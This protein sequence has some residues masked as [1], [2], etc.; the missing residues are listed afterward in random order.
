MQTGATL[1]VRHDRIP[2]ASGKFCSG[3]S[4]HSHTMHS[5]EYLGRLPHYIA[6]IPVASYVIEREVGWMHLY[7]GRTIDFSKMY[8]T[9]P[10]SP[11]EA[12][13]LERKQVEEKL[14][15]QA[16]VSLSDHDNIEA[17]LHLQMLE[18][19][20][21]APVS[22]EWSVPYDQT[23]FHLGVHNLPLSRATAWMEELARFTAN[24]RT[25][26]LRQLL[27]ELN[28]EPSVLLI[29]NH[30]YW[31]AESVGP[32]QHRDSLAIF[33][34]KYGHLL[35]SLEFNGMRSRSEN[36]QVLKLSKTTDLPVVS[37]GDRHGCEPNA[38][39]NLSAAAT[40]A[41]FVDEIRLERRSQVVLMPQYFEPLRLRLLEG[42]WH[43][44]SDAPGEFGRAHWM[45]RVF[46]PGADDSHRPLSDFTG[47][48]FQRVVD[49]FRRIMAFLV[50]PKM[51]PA[52]RLTFLGNEEGGL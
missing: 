9:P 37:G 22:V 11:R 25:D 46:I 43:A 29:L 20:K 21:R 23:V 8:W 32:D 1:V 31:D 5:R 39:L 2:Q 35:H 18:R 14:G 19:T 50:S 4:L 28:A 16:L 45:T 15:L 44:L 6:K 13:D 24:P 41:D 38:V 10:L 48:R 34:Q 42:A 49:I 30:P 3:V 51:R 33:L 7:E 40:F 17:G 52:V 27:H 47:T 26:V 12:F 36:E